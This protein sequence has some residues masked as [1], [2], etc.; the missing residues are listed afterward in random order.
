MLS[1]NTFGSG[2]P[3][4]QANSGIEYIDIATQTLYIQNQIP[5]GAAWVV[6]ARNVFPQ[7]P[8]AAS[9]TNEGLVFLSVAP[10]DPDVPIAVG[11]NDPLFAEIDDNIIAMAAAL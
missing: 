8:S 11:I 2:T 10:A 6:K 1:F 4:F 7:L 9:S 5:F 3:T